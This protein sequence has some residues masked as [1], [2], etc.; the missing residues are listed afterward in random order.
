MVQKVNF[1]VLT[2]DSLTIGNTVI[3]GT[4]V[5]VSGESLSS[6]TG[7]AEVYAN[8]SQFPLTD[9]TPGSFAFA[10]NNNTLY[11]TNGSGWYKIALINQTPSI[12]LSVESVSLGETGNTADITYTISEPEGTPTTVSISNSGIANTSVANVQLFTSNNTI[13]INN[14]AN[15]DSTFTATITATVSDGVNLGTDSVSVNVAYISFIPDSKYTRALIT[16]DGNNGNNQEFIDHGGS[17]TIT[18]AN[19]SNQRNTTFSPYRHGGYSHYFNFD[20]NNQAGVTIAHDN[21]LNLSN[22]DWTIEFWYWIASAGANANYNFISKGSNASVRPYAINFRLDSTGGVEPRGFFSTNGSSQQGISNNAWTDYETWHHVAFVRSNGT[23][24]RYI[25]G[26]AN[27]TTTIDVFTNTENLEIGAV[28]SGARQ[29]AYIKD[30]RISTVARYTSNFTV[31]TETLTAETGTEL[32]LFDKPYVVDGSTNDHTP[33]FQY[34]F[35]GPRSHP[36][37]P[38][39]NVEY[40]E[41]D[42]GG[43][44]YFQGSGWL[45]TDSADY[46]LGTG[47]AFT[48]EFWYCFDASQ[49]HTLFDFYDNT[50]NVAKLAITQTNVYLYDGSTNILAL[51]RDQRLGQWEHFCWTRNASNQHV[52]YINGE[53]VGTST[54]STTMDVDRIDIAR[55]GGTFNNTNM[56]GWIS[57][58]SI[59]KG[60]VTRTGAFDPP[61][62]PLSSTGK[63]LHIKGTDAHVLDKSQSRQ[64]VRLAGSVAANTSQSKYAGSSIEIPSGDTLVRVESELEEGIGSGDFTIECWARSPSTTTGYFGIFVLESRFMNSSGTSQGLQLAFRSGGTNFDIYHSSGTNT[65]PTFNWATNTWYHI[66][67]VRSGNTIRLYVDGTLVTPTAS[68]STDYTAFKFLTVGMYYSSSY[69]LGGFIEDFRVTDGLARY[70][71]NFTPPS[72]ALKG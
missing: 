54:S 32:L 39:D 9:L 12:T 24:T 70:T 17:H 4:G 33:L 30:L 35:S 19:Y 34:A 46:E 69:A 27:G 47:T 21:T 26:V 53:Q 31:P 14:F 49:T 42:H 16:T 40:S 45:E 52:F 1:N 62:S 72:A 56:I 6:G 63:V 38:F 51:S 60:S 58:F 43:S 3:D 57:D 7:G 5:T 36:V 71:S 37:T 2:G 11:L 23:I 18:A 44:I 64:W 41:A 48:V 55:R 25:N 67:M 59:T 29:P 15:A 66:A 68:S 28:T 10:N 13:R 8:S 50:V 20:Q 61:T 65:T 22:T